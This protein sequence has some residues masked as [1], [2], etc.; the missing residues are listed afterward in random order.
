MFSTRSVYSC[1]HSRLLVISAAFDS[2]VPSPGGTLVIFLPL[3]RYSWI[4]EANRFRSFSFSILLVFAIR[5]LYLLATLELKGEVQ[6][7]NNVDYSLRSRRFQKLID[8]V[9]AEFHRKRK[10][11]LQAEYQAQQAGESLVLPPSPE[12]HEPE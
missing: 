9:V 6:M 7:K 10:A 5:D 8:P 3:L 4:W 12:P 11:L 2:N 1:F